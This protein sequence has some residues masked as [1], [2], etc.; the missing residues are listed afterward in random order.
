MPS[1]AIRRNQSYCL[2]NAEKEYLIRYDDQSIAVAGEYVIKCKADNLDTVYVVGGKKLKAI[3]STSVV[4]GFYP[5]SVE[6]ET[7]Q[8]ITVKVCSYI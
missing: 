1:V 7:R 6:V 3:S 8:N 4:Y 2:Q 5:S